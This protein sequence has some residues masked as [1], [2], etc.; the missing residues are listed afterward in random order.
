MKIRTKEGDALEVLEI[1]ISG[2]S[3]TDPTRKI[4]TD[5]RK[6]FDKDFHMESES[7]SRFST[8]ELSE[9]IRI[10]LDSREVVERLTY[11]IQV[12]ED[13][14]ASK[15]K[16]KVE[17][18]SNELVSTTKY[19]A[20]YEIRVTEKYSSLSVNVT[21][22]VDNTKPIYY[23]LGGKVRE[24]HRVKRI[25]EDMVY[26]DIVETISLI[27]YATVAKKKTFLSKFTNVKDFLDVPLTKDTE[28]VKIREH[29]EVPIETIVESGFIEVN[30]TALVLSTSRVLVNPIKHSIESFRV[31]TSN[32]ELEGKKYFRVVGT[33]K[34][35]SGEYDFNPNYDNLSIVALVNG[36]PIEVN[37]EDVIRHVYHVY[38]NKVEA[39][40][41]AEQFETYIK[42]RE[43]ML[44]DLAVRDKLLKTKEEKLAKQE[45]GASKI[46]AQTSKLREETSVLGEDAKIK[47][48][49]A[50]SMKEKI[51]V[52]LE[53]A[54]AKANKLEKEADKAEADKLHIDFKTIAVSIGII[55]SGYVLYQTLKPVG[56]EGIGSAVLKQV[57][58]KLI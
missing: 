46:V 40:N 36:E 39:D 15:E 9:L 34:V 16:E 6:L 44:Q 32:P 3:L 26:I 30:K 20:D 13:Y 55:G 11:L 29:I 48:K 41:L 56:K 35:V 49:T 14:N 57:V 4:F 54:R 5:L 18:I 19:N 17:T 58:K 8:D 22:H 45:V 27:N 12:V 24:L 7:F 1:I 47:K 50:E 52:E 38:K 37:N 31:R 10:K 43:D 23:S 51:A 28:F 53:E 25:P 42:D 33:N 2:L 21:M